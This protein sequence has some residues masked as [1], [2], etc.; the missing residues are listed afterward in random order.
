MKKSSLIKR[1]GRQ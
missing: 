1:V